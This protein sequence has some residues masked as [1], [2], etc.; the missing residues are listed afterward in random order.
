MSLV[1][2][3]LIPLAIAILIVVDRNLNESPAQSYGHEAKQHDRKEIKGSIGE[4]II[5][6]KLVS[7]YGFAPESIYRNI[8]VPDKRGNTAEIDIVIASR[9]GLLVFECKNFSGTI[10]GDAKMDNW[11][12]YVGQEK[13]FFYS[14][15]KQNKKHCRVLKNYLAEVGDIPVIPFV[16]VTGGGNWKVRN[17]SNTDYMIELNC[18]FNEIYNWL[19]ES[20]PMI[21]NM[22]KVKEVLSRLANVDDSVKVEHVASIVHNR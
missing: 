1:F 12:Q 7:K 19:P 5:S 15:I 14:P 20:Q 17:L 2:L 16:A 4:D 13:N 18:S 11:I 10:Y 21:E 8:Y 3:F 6:R 22:D 9:K